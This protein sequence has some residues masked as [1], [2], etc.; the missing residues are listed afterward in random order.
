MHGLVIAL[1]V[2]ICIVFFIFN[3]VILIS[4][5]DELYRSCIFTP[6]RFTRFKL[7]RDGNNKYYIKYKCFFFW[8][9]WG[10]DY[11]KTINYHSLKEAKDKMQEL[12][13]DIKRITQQGKYTNVT[14]LENE[15]EG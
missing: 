7:V 2:F 9:W 14:E 3:M 5:R 6:A 1:I 4:N 10:N 8:R 15:L 11:N 12:Q 13:N